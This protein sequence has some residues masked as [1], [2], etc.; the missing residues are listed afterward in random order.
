MTSHKGISASCYARMGGEVDY[1]VCQQDLHSLQAYQSPLAD[2]CYCLVSSSSSAS[3]MSHS[4]W[5]DLPAV[6]KTHVVLTCFQCQK[7]CKSAAVLQHMQVHTDTIRST[8]IT[9]ARSTSSDKATA[10]HVLE[11]VLN[12]KMH[13]LLK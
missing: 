3:G 1:Q 10:I 4:V 9:Y 2:R 11:L 12:Q 6:T 5:S 13:G 7:A 8:L